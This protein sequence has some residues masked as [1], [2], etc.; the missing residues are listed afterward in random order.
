M[1]QTKK[2][3]IDKAWELHRSL[4]PGPEWE[5]RRSWLKHHLLVQGY[6]CA[7]C[8]VDLVVGREKG[9]EELQA[10]IDHIIPRSVQGPDRIDNTLAACA[11]CNNCKASF[12][13]R[14]FLQGAQFAQRFVDLDPCP[15]QLCAHPK[16][17][18]Y[19]SLSIDRGIHVFLNDQEFK[20]VHEYDVLNGWVRLKVPKQK[21]RSGAPMTIKKEGEVRVVF[22]DVQRQITRRSSDDFINQLM[23]SLQARQ[24]PEHLPTIVPQD[25]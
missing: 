20:N 3:Q 1:E 18:L 22:Y 2:E 14:E 5:I 8:S 16:S 7:Y 24:F 6:K 10:T 21:S 25:L 19:D 12:S 11:R 9:F 13:I 17:D 23:C 15:L 4:N